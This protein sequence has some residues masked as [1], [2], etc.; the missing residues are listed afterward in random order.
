MLQLKA[1]FLNLAP[2]TKKR[3]GQEELWRRRNA[4]SFSQTFPVTTIV[5]HARGVCFLA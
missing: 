2:R 5:P 1:F 4:P 3:C